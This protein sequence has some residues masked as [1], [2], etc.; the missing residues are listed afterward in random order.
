MVNGLLD[1]G[2]G[3]GKSGYDYDRKL[4]II[5]YALPIKLKIVEVTFYKCLTYGIHVKQMLKKVYAKVGTLVKVKLQ[6]NL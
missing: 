4:V 6:L 2:D 1:T 3:N 5:P